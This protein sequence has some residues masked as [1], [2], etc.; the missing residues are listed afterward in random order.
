M[1]HCIRDSGYRRLVLNTFETLEF[2][3][4]F[5]KASLLFFFFKSNW[6]FFYQFLGLG[7]LDARS[8]EPWQNQLVLSWAKKIRVGGEFMWGSSTS[9]RIGAQ[10]GDYKETRNHVSPLHVICGK[11]WRND[12]TSIL[13]ET[14]DCPTINAIRKT[15]LEVM[16]TKRAEA[17]C[18]RF[19]LS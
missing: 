10:K 2:V 18:G 12:Q 14:G 9:F 8:L 19:V 5:S 17:A 16:H 1:I 15:D 11:G 6:T 4:K 13:D 7:G 3:S